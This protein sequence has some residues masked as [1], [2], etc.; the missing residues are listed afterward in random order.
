MIEVCHIYVCIPINSLKGFANRDI[1]IIDKKNE[2]AE[3]AS[4]MG[5]MKHQAVLPMSYAIWEELISVFKIKEPMILHRDE[6]DYSNVG[7]KG[8]YA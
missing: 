4:E 5:K 3:A 8:W 1:E 2:G 6:E 7:A